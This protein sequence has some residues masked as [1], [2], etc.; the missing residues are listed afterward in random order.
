M[1][2]I[3][4]LNDKILLEIKLDSGYNIK[5]RSLYYWSDLYNS[6]V[7]E[8]EN[9]ASL[10]RTILINIL[11]DTKLNT[12]NF[13]TS[14]RL[15][16]LNTNEELSDFQ[17]I[18][19]IEIEKVLMSKEDS[20]LKGWIEF[21]KDPN[22]ELTE[23]FEEK[24][25]DIAEAK[26]ILI[27]LSNDVRQREFYELREKM[28]KDKLIALN[29]T[30]KRALEKGKEIGQEIG[31]E[32]GL[33]EEALNAKMDIAKNLLDVLDD[34]TISMKTGLEINKITEMRK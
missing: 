15:K 33:E 25:D 5:N 28:I 27:N 22:S 23:Y 13:H 1:I 29:T 17:E 6:Q 32:K 8:R 9:C 14:Y 10:K 20:I 26:N 19:F 7:T 3:D 2:G 21:L 31:L 12:K 30:E 4:E 34:W 11:N 16:E 18:H 24:F